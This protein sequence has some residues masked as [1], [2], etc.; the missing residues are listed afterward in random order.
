MDIHF[1]NLS[2]SL[3]SYYCCIYHNNN[4]NNIK[5]DYTV[6]PSLYL[7][8]TNCLVWWFKRCFRFS[9]CRV[10][11]C[12]SVCFM[13]CF[14]DDLKFGKIFQFYE[15]CFC[16]VCMFVTARALF[17]EPANDPW[18][19]PESCKNNNNII[20]LQKFIHNLTSS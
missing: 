16:F 6:T 4:D 3:K 18:L 20:Y 9:A 2:I 8:T 7:M 17:S 11:L 15:I 5:I 1:W 13:G 12:V 14:R 19:E 10:F